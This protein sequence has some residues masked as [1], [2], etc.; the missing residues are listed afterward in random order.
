MKME[1]N[2]KPTI[3]NEFITIYSNNLDTKYWIDLIETVSKDSY[4]LQSIARRPHLT[5]D[6]PVCNDRK[7]SYAAIELRCLFQNIMN[8]SLF[9][10]MK[11]KN[12]KYMEPLRS[13]ITVS[14]LLPF[15]PMTEHQDITDQRVDSFVAMLY[16]NDDY[17]GGELS[18]PNR[19][20]KYKPKAG[21]LAYYKMNEMHGVCETTNGLRYTIGYGILGPYA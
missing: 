13:T 21:D 1:N 16:V 9:K 19:K 15:T 12:M 2:I 8:K 20:Y 17:D 6:L 11:D 10:F 14:K 4:P 5:M 7:D 3:D 18:L